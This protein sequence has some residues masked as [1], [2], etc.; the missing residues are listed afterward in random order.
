[1]QG[2][3][4]ITST[5]KNRHVCVT[6]PWYGRYNTIQYWGS[7]SMVILR[8]ILPPKQLVGAIIHSRDRPLVTKK[9]GTGERIAR[10]YEVGTYY[11]SS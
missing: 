3:L 10:A 6:E 2:G 9:T 4:G 8:S 5:M 11:Y 7:N 1:M